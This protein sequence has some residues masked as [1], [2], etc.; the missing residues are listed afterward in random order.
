MLS[1]VLFI[2]Q[3]PYERVPEIYGASDLCI[4][5]LASSLVTEAVPSKVYRIMAAQRRVLAIT[6]SESDLAAVVAES[7]AG[8]VVAPGNP[9]ALRDAVLAV[10]ESP[11]DTAAKRGRDYVVQRVGRDRI[12]KEYSLLLNAALTHVAPEASA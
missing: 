12:I 6:T 3:Q 8:I 9:Q 7:G 1:N 2:P 10:V 5:P 11:D 4:V